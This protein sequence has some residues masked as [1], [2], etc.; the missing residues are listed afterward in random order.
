M[1]VRIRLQLLLLQKKFEIGS[2]EFQ[3]R[4]GFEGARQGIWLVAVLQSKIESTGV[5][6]TDTSTIEQHT[7][8]LV[9]KDTGILLPL[10]LHEKKTTIITIHDR[11]PTFYCS[12][13]LDVCRLGTACRKIPA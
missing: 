13:C 5:G 6:N 4:I 10:E 11:A 1:V 2:V 8:S 3:A 9:Q 7:T 12:L